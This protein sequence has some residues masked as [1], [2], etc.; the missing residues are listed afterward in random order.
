MSAKGIRCK[1]FTE[2]EKKKMLLEI[3]EKDRII[4]NKQT[5]GVTTAK[6]ILGMERNCPEFN[7]S[8]HTG[9]RSAKQLLSLYDHLKKCY[10]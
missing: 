2:F 9:S 5:D 1:N 10:N 3:T 7:S 8:D 6:K 4:E